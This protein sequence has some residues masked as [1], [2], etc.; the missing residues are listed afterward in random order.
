M[1]VE[2]PDISLRI[3]WIDYS[4]K[5]E[6]RRK[7]CVEV[8]LSISGYRCIFSVSSKSTKFTRLGGTL[9]A[10]NGSSSGVEELLVVF[11]P[12]RLA[13]TTGTYSPPPSPAHHIHSRTIHVQNTPKFGCCVTI[14]VIGSVHLSQLN[15][16][17]NPQG[18]TLRTHGGRRG[19]AGREG[20]RMAW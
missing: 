2:S 5:R 12:S 7:R 3:V 15:L 6:E 19:G 8:I 14:I 17:K 4:G 13:F 1:N 18:H 16:T 11:L 9:R 10:S 20:G